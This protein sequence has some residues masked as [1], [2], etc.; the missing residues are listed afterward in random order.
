MAAK[1]N[2]KPKKNQ[3]KV[4]T[5]SYYRHDCHVQSSHPAEPGTFAVYGPTFGTY[6]PDLGAIEGPE[7][8][9]LLPLVAWCIYTAQPLKTTYR[10]SGT[11]VNTK[12]VGERTVKNGR[13]RSHAGGLVVPR[14]HTCGLMIDEEIELNDDELCFLGYM[15]PGET[16][17]DV[18]KRL[19]LGPYD[20]HAD[21]RAERRAAREA[22]QSDDDD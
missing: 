10:H 1:R 17:D 6:D 22:E 16:P 3:P 19:Q 9:T 15:M 13:L 4:R 8:L 7:A 21:S 12:L 20:R 2:P 14:L 11:G 5:S 18:L